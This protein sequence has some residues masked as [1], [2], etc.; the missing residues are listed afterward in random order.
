LFWIDT[1]SSWQNAVLGY[2]KTANKF[3]MWW[4]A[5]NWGTGAQVASTTV[6]VDTWYRID[7]RVNV[8]AGLNTVDWKVDGANQTQ[9]T[10]SQT[11]HTIS[12]A[13]IGG[14]TSNETYTAFIDDV[15]LTS[16]ASE[17]P[18]GPGGVSA[19]VPDGMGAS[20]DPGARMQDDDSTAWDTN[21]FTR[22]RDVPMSS[23]TD[24]VKQTSTS[25][26]TYLEF[27]LG[28]TA[29]GCIQG[30]RA[31]AAYRSN[32]SGT[33]TGAINLNDGGT[34]R[35]LYSGTLKVDATRTYRGSIIAPASGGWNATKLNA[36]TARVGYAT[37][38]GGTPGPIP[39]WDALMV[40]YAWG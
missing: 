17:Y 12:T 37:I 35:T 34:D 2:D 21:S 4:Y 22:V 14:D 18:L 36:L 31:L 26:T 9:A 6:A 13:A 29:L 1:S 27:T 32:G 10:Y 30:V 16:G 19:V 39:Y 25:A 40:E 28:D 15:L 23:G 33:L 8:S 38:G 24:Y 5:D 3:K 7:M 11:A 20:S